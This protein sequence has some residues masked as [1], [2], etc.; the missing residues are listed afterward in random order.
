MDEDRTGCLV[1]RA[2][3]ARQG[4]RASQV[5]LARLERLAS[6]ALV[7]GKA[8]MALLDLEVPVVY[9]D[10]Q[11]ILARKESQGLL[12]EIQSASP[13]LKASQAQQGSKVS[14]VAVAHEG[15]VDGVGRMA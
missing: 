10:Q 2:C 13:D 15:H 5:C 12:E 3:R 11:D 7:A 1:R 4:C 14:W 8:A 9:Q 6:E